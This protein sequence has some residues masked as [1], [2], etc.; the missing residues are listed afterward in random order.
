MA[1]PDFH[2]PSKDAFAQLATDALRSAGVSGEI[3]YIAEKFQLVIGGKGELVRYA[4][5]GNA[6][7]EY[8]HLPLEARPRVLAR[9]FANTQ[10]TV[11]DSAE[12]AL[13]KIL[14]RVRDRSYYALVGMQ[15]ALNGPPEAK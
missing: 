10:G 7:E 2:T 12:S 5:L 9:F 1:Y 15:L 13:P 11:D 8:C 4:F 6:Y 14:P 3:K